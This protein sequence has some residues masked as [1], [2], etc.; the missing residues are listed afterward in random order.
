[1]IVK[2]FLDRHP[3]D[4]LNDPA[5]DLA[6]VDGRVH[7]RAEVV[8]AFHV[9]DLVTTSKA[10]DCHTDYR[11][12]IHMVRKRMTFGGLPIEVY[13]GRCVVSV[14]AEIHSLQVRVHY[15]CVPVEAR[16]FTISMNE[17]VPK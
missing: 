14:L 5:F 7:G 17:A 6:V 3:A 1:M 13:S 8:T 9:I 16:A 2:N 4:A 10:I 15:E 12:S 11:G